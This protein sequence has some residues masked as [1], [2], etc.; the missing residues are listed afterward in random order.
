ME[1]ASLFITSLVSGCGQK[2][3]RLY[4]S[5]TRGKL[6]EPDVKAAVAKIF[7]YRKQAKSVFFLF[8][9]IYHEVLRSLKNIFA[10]LHLKATSMEIREGKSFPS[11]F[12]KNADVRIFVEIQG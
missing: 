11:F 12:Q 2:L 4:F 5:W 10:L 7:F 8:P 1:E 9:A 6:S 3:L